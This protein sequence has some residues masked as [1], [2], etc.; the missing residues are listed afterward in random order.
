AVRRDIGPYRAAVAMDRMALRAQVSEDDLTAARIAPV[1]AKVRGHFGHNL[2]ALRVTLFA[3]PA[4]RFFHGPE[5]LAIIAFQNFP[6]VI[7]MEHTLG[8]LVCEHRIKELPRPPLPLQKQ[9]NCEWLKLRREAGVFAQEDIRK[10]RI[11]HP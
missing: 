9:I 5:R 6:Q 1:A 2:L 7:C 3:N 4:K 11:F 10:L 8:E